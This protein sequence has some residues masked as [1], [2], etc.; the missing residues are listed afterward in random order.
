MTLW[1]CAGRASIGSRRLL[2]PETGCL[3]SVVVRAWAA[4][5]VPEAAR[6][7]C[8]RPFLPAAYL[9]SQTGGLR[10]DC[11]ALCWRVLIAVLTVALAGYA[12]DGVGMTTPEQAM[13][14]CNS[15]RCPSHGHHGQDCCK[16]MPSVH[17][18][19]G[20]PSSMQGVSFSLIA[21]GMHLSKAFS[22]FIAETTIL[23]SVGEQELSW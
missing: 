5:I 20:Q 22:Q 17:A 6:S 1:R 21:L 2:V 11:Y 18:A 13:Q 4:P 23:K 16:S 19:F 7:S 14:C 15:M 9:D 12:L 8:S 10:S 3:F